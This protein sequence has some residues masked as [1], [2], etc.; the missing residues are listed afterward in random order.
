MMF[1]CITLQTHLFDKI[2]EIL[3]QIAIVILQVNENKLDDITVNVEENTKKRSRFAS[4]LITHDEN[5]NDI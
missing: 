3:L 5:R 1:C 4:F 2:R